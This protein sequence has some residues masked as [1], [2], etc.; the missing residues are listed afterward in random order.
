M[1]PKTEIG[2]INGAKFRVDIPKTG[3]AV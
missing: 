2:E 3:M 1:E